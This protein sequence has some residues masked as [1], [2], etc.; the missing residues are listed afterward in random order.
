MDIMNSHTENISTENSRVCLLD[1]PVSNHCNNVLFPAEQPHMRMESSESQFYLLTTASWVFSHPLRTR[2]HV[3]SMI[4]TMMN[5][6]L[7]ILLTQY[8]NYM[9]NKD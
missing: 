5:S 1:H 6:N 4:S 9:P 8:R 7:P 2:A 3:S